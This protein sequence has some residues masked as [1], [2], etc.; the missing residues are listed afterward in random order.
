MGKKSKMI[1]AGARG[2][3]GPQRVPTTTQ[4][5]EHR[6]PFKVDKDYGGG[7]VYGVFAYAHLGG[8]CLYDVHSGSGEGNG[9]HTPVFNTLASRIW[10]YN[11]LVVGIGDVNSVLCDEPFYPRD[12]ANSADEF[13]TW[14]NTLI[15]QGNWSRRKWFLV[16]YADQNDPAWGARI[17]APRKKP[18]AVQRMNEAEKLVGQLV[19]AIGA[20]DP[21]NRRKVVKMAVPSITR[22]I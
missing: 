3:V 17:A 4:L 9:N 16:H 8:Y 14:F 13:I 22:C 19:T 7:T 2:P 12:K 5:R 11:P 18:V 21:E 6:M 15:S 20:L 10:A 1:V